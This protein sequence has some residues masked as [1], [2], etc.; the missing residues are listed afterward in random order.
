MWFYCVFFLLLREIL[1]SHKGTSRRHR[2]LES[3]VV[4]T[5]D[6]SLPFAFLAYAL[7][8]KRRLAG[9]VLLWSSSIGYRW[10]DTWPSQQHVR[11]RTQILAFSDLQMLSWH[12]GDLHSSLNSWDGAGYL[13]AGS[14]TCR[15]SKLRQCRW[16]LKNKWHGQFFWGLITA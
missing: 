6:S 8:S 14:L 5:M 7:A 1:K 4:F 10:L 12:V 15:G 3:Y 9:Y 16:L 13:D 11:G 2:V